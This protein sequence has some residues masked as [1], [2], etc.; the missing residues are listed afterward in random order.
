MLLVGKDVK[1]ASNGN[2]VN[3][4]LTP[5]ML[6]AGSVGIYT[7]GADGKIRLI[8][9]GSAGAGQ[10][11]STAVKS[12]QITMY[13]GLGSGDNYISETH[14]VAGIRNIF[15]SAYRLGSGETIYIGYNGTTGAAVG[16]FL[17]T[18]EGL[19]A[20]VPNDPD[21]LYRQEASIKFRVR[22]KGNNEFGNMHYI[23]AKVD[24]SDDVNS[25]L[26]K[27]VA[28]TNQIGPYE[29]KQYFTA[30]L[31]GG[32]LSAPVQSAPATATTG[33]SIAA[34]APV[35]LKVFTK[36]SD[37]S[38][39]AGSNE[40]TITVGSGTSTNTVTGN[41][42]N[43]AGNSGYRV[44]IGSTSGTY[45]K[46]FDV[47][48]DV[49]TLVYTGA[50]G[51]AGTPPAAVTGA[52]IKLVAID[53]TEFY[54]V[55]N[56]GVLEYSPVTVIGIVPSSGSPTQLKE[57]ELDSNAYRGDLYTLCNL[58][59]HLINQIDAASTYD[60]YQIKS[61]NSSRN[62][63]GQRALVDQEIDTFVAFVV[64]G[65]VVDTNQQANFEDILTDIYPA[66][67]PVIS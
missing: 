6:D 2:T 27:L 43:V 32:A 14:D 36:A 21:L 57:F 17:S 16:S 19:G 11:S 42:V 56:F 51:T 25:V 66:F 50:A 61:I 12:G 60:L 52:G 63:D 5:D 34:S 62:K 28:A 65:N 48:A 3:A 67:A 38:L 10:V 4:A 18:Q 7:T 1:Y 30:S 54:S 24:P 53:T 26:A 33:G 40:Q 15:A 64:Q 37:G 55:S 9:K 20:I 23:T 49:V 29:T 35:F 58:D 46:Y 13:V 59:K 44:Y 39:S 22:K 45:T 8:I 47:A 41:W 31:V